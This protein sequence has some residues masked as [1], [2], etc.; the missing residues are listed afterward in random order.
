M[1]LNRRKFMVGS[2]G[3]AALAGLGAGCSD[4]NGGGSDAPDGGSP[5]G[6]ASPDTP[7]SELAV[8]RELF[9]HGVASGDPSA[10][11]VILWTRVTT[12]VLSSPGG[13]TAASSEVSAD[14]AV[15]WRMALDPELRQLV[16]QGSVRAS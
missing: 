6:G 10:D 3:V 2:A 7:L 4:D 16:A 14:I 15:E 1:T 8:D 9:P 11:A 12:P 13:G 5:D